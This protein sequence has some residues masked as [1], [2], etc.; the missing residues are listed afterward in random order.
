LKLSEYV[1]STLYLWNKYLST[2][3]GSVS[4]GKLKLERGSL[5]Y[6]NLAL[7]TETKDHFIF[8]LLGADEHFAGLKAFNHK[9]PST[10]E[11]LGQFEG[12]KENPIFQLGARNSGLITLM[13][14]SEIDLNA[15]KERFGFIT[16]QWKTHL[17]RKGKNGALFSFSK[18]F[19]SFFINNCLVINRLDEIYRVK[20]ILYAEIIS[21]GFPE[22]EYAG[23]LSKR[24]N[25]PAYTTSELVGVHYVMDSPYHDYAL[26]GQFANVFL[27]PELR[28]SRIGEFL[29]KHPSFICRALNCRGYLYNKKFEWVEGNPNPEE[30]SIQP[31][32]MLEREDGSY[33][34][35]DLKTAI[36]RKARITK[37]QHRRRRFIDYVD[38]GTGQLANYAEYFKFKKN[39]EWAWSRY[40]VRVD[41]PRLILIVGNYEN[42]PREEIEE[43]SRKLRPNYQIIDYDTLNAFFLQKSQAKPQ[44]RYRDLRTGRL[45]KK[46]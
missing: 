43:A 30:K 13:L 36:M 21:K 20:Y 2:L 31:D 11:Y 25:K 37:G 39:A 46:P 32:L 44:V 8:E 7:F 38:E 1:D 19:Q 18:T 35:C 3:H 4:K 6:P 14:S 41:N 24:L 26:S 27:L 12:Q 10:V 28:E 9:Y 15:V 42:A 45:I 23:D 40:K 16:D 17:V 29:R 5:L 34:I 33:D 22:E